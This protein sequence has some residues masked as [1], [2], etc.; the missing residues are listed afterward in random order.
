MRTG[1]NEQFVPSKTE[2]RPTEQIMEL[3]PSPASV[4]GKH[5]ACL[6]LIAKWY[7]CEVAFIYCVN[8]VP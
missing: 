2:T 1:V 5:H 7:Y 6:Q 4:P 8:L 3:L